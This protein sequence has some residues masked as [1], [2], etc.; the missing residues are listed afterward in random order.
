MP[1]ETMFWFKNWFANITYSFFLRGLIFC[2]TSNLGLTQILSYNCH[3]WKASF[4]AL[5]MKLQLF[6]RLNLQLHILHSKDLVMIM[7]RFNVNII[8]YFLKKICITFEGFIFLVWVFK[9]SFWKKIWAQMI[10]FS[11]ERPE[12]YLF[13]NYFFLKSCFR[14]HYI[15]VNGFFLSWMDP[16]CKFKF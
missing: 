2:N 7:N 14:K 5:C 16:M 12:K 6:F 15:P 1:F 9:W 3:I 4:V 10:Q 8:P 11:N 13:S